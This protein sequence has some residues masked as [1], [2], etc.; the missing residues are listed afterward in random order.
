VSYN[1][2]III[3][4]ETADVKK[5]E[6]GQTFEVETLVDKITVTG[7]WRFQPDNP[8]QKDFTPKSLDK[9]ISGD[10]KKEVKKNRAYYPLPL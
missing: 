10:I 3:E 5:I 6:I 1:H 2:Y 4:K 7:F 9:M 8:F